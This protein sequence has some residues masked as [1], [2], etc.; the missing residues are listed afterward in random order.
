MEARRGKIVVE[1]RFARSR[2]KIGDWQRGGN[3]GR[4]GGWFEDVG[5]PFLNGGSGIYLLLLSGGGGG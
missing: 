2:R 4:F 5:Y 3:G 1:S